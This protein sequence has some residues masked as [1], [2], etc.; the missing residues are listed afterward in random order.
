MSNVFKIGDCVFVIFF[1][2][3]GGVNLEL[4]LREVWNGVNVAV[5]V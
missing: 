2:V 1:V 4:L 5:G 3:G